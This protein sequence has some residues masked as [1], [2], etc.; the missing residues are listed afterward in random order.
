M[1]VMEETFYYAEGLERVIIEEGVTYIPSF[2]HCQALTELKLPS[3][4]KRI[5][6]PAYMNFIDLTSIKLLEIPEG[7]LYLGFYLFYGSSLESVVLPSTIVDVKECAFLTDTLKYVYFR[8]TE[9]QCCQD[10][11]V[12]L[13]RTEATIYYYSETRPTGSGNYWHYVDGKPVIWRSN[14]R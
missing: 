11:L 6:E 1:K 8:G 7:V 2:Y 3:T 5:G 12:E 9:E 13:A 10:I 14:L 4:A